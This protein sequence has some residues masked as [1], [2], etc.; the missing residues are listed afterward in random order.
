MAGTAVFSDV[1]LPGGNIKF[2]IQVDKVELSEDLQKAARY[3][4]GGA[5]AL[6]VLY[7]SEFLKALIQGTMNQVFGDDSVVI[8]TG[9]LHVQ[10]HF[11][12]NKGFLDVLSK[13]ELGKIKE[14]LQ[15]KFS[16]FGFKVE[17]LK[18]EIENEE[19]VR[20]TKEAISLCKRY[21]K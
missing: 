20:K 8:N 12:T 2:I 5:T 3:R 21:R 15:R 9:S 13:H 7:D 14:L 18:V 6:G 19:D 16:E 1:H 11:P 17:G 4:V 10:V